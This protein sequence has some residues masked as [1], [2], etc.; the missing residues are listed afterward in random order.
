MHLAPRVISIS[1]VRTDVR[2]CEMEMT[3]TDVR[4]FLPD[5]CPDFC[6][7]VDLFG[8]ACISG[9]GALRSSH[10]CPVVN[11]NRYADRPLETILGTS[12]GNVVSTAVYVFPAI[13][14][15]VPL[16]GRI[17]RCAPN[18]HASA[19]RRSRDVLRPSHG[20]RAAVT[21]W[22]FST[23]SRHEVH[24]TL[25]RAHKFYNK[26]HDNPTTR[27]VRSHDNDNS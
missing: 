26:S 22:T 20:N 6:A 17:T 11:V 15:L 14:R 12:R 5:A 25:T 9:L 1:E 13:S 19:P 7:S 16:Y 18:G 21:A 2:F 24:A 27:K 3:R 8:P 10:V 4:P 23:I